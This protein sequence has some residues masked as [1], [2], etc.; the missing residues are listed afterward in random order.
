MPLRGHAQRRSAHI[1]GAIWT[2]SRIVVV[3][4]EICRPGVRSVAP[5]KRRCFGLAKHQIVIDLERGGPL[6]F[7]RSRSRTRPARVFTVAEP[8]SPLVNC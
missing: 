5:M 4:E 1:S 3:A 2:L 8:A 7:W 6:A